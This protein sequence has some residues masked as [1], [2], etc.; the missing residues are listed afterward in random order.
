LCL[1]NASSEE[2]KRKRK[3]S[4]ME[5]WKRESDTWLKLAE[6]HPG[7]SFGISGE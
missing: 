2:K 3:V 7:L 1:G 6:L 4:S 5:P